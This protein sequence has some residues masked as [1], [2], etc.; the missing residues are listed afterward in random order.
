MFLTLQPA[1]CDAAAHSN[2]K[3]PWRLLAP[4]WAPLGGP[5]HWPPDRYAHMLIPRL[6]LC[7]S[8]WP[9]KLNRPYLGGSHHLSS[10][11]LHAV[12]FPSQSMVLQQPRRLDPNPDFLIPWFPSLPSSPLLHLIKTVTRSR[13]ANFPSSLG[14]VSF[15][16]PTGSMSGPCCFSLGI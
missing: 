2:A 5:A 4:S 7:V 16:L 15:S 11:L 3:A 14:S 6:F 13:P 12:V 9:L 8:S 1:V 10:Q